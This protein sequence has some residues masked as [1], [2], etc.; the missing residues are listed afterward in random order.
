[1]GLAILSK[2]R[3]AILD[4]LAAALRGAS[5]LRAILS[6]HAGLSDE[7]GAPADAVGKLLRPSLVLF[8]ADQ[9]GAPLDDALPA[10]VGLELIHNFSLIHDDI[11]DGDGVRRG[12][13]TVWST[14][15]VNEAI[16]AGDLMHTLA[17]RSALA[18][19]SASASL[20]L[21]ATEAMI[22]GQSMDLSF[23]TRWVILDEYV[24]MIDRKT[25]ALIVAAFELGGAAADADTA[26]RAVLTKLGQAVGRAFQIQDDLLG[27]WGN[28]GIV[29]KPHASDIRQRK[30]SYP[31]LLAFEH[32]DDPD[33][34]SLRRIYEGDSPTDA[35]VDWVIDLMTRLQIREAG[36]TAVKELLDEASQ[37]LDSLPFS[38]EGRRDFEE[39]TNYLARRNK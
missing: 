35:D 36:C 17:I 38:A 27:I 5:H 14:W 25:G 18:S 16:N 20:L 12:R 13:P 1:M 34:A 15:G 9:L 39:L 10:A 21:N 4:G 22:E 2:Y 8:V 19:G 29:G 23:E 7:Q 24:E 11:Q 26:T 33:L 30:K 6:Y 37:A 32:A 31:T 28:A 3:T